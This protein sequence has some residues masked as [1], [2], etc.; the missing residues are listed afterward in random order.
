MFQLQLDLM[1]TA[2]APRAPP[3]AA[4]DSAWRLP[5]ARRFF[6]AALRGWDSAGGGGFIYTCK[7][8]PGLPF[9]D[10]HKYKWPQVRITTFLL[11]QVA[12]SI[13]PSINPLHNRL[14]HCVPQAEGIAAVALLAA[15]SIDKKERS[16]YLEWYDRIWAFS[17]AHLA[18]H[19]NGSYF[20]LLT[21]ALEKVEVTKVCAP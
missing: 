4:E 16:E 14:C 13:A 20:R 11:V 7:P 9:G 12:N 2:S 5:P 8:E 15:A 10:D 1:A 21:R 19:I 18:D 3:E 17:W 6:D